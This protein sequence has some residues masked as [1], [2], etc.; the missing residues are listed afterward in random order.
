MNDQ[1][2]VTVVKWFCNVTSIFTMLSGPFIFKREKAAEK[3]E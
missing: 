1:N 3:K 2:I